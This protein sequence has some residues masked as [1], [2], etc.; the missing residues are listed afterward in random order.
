MLATAWPTNNNPTNFGI[1]TEG[2]TVITSSL[3][4]LFFVAAGSYATPGSFGSGA[5]HLPANASSAQD[6]TASAHV[7]RTEDKLVDV[8]IKITLNLT[9]PAPF[10]SD[11]SEARIC[12][13]PVTNP[14]MPVRMP[15][16]RN[17]PPI[18]RST[19]QPLFLQVQVLNGSGQPLVPAFPPGSAGLGQ[20]AARWLYGGELALI[21]INYTLP[22]DNPAHILPIT[23]AD[24]ASYFDPEVGPTSMIISV[25][26]RYLSDAPN[27]R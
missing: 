17:L 16:G 26:G 6:D 15:Q 27:P 2:E 5:T 20:V 13:L 7:L 9:L 19:F 18:D 12:A 3:P 8:D 14:T 22:N 21:N 25:K 23:A 10:P 4:Q 1:R 24:L 11:A